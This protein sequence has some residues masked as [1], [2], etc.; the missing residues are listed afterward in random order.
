[1]TARLMTDQRTRLNR[2]R[3][4]TARRHGALGRTTKVT[5]ACQLLCGRVARPAAFIA[6]VRLCPACLAR[7]AEIAPC[8]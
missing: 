2:H 4:E 3:D 6:G 1:M 5:E 7:L 8:A